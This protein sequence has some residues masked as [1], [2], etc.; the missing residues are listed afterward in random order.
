MAKPKDKFKSE[1][2]P[3]LSKQ[4]RSNFSKFKTKVKSLAKKGATKTKNVAKTVAT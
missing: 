4:N 3:K 2:A 1:K